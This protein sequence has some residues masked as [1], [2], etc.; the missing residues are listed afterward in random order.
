MYCTKLIVKTIAQ[1]NN[2]AMQF[3]WCNSLMILCT[4]STMATAPP[5][6]RKRTLINIRGMCQSSDSVQT[7]ERR[8][9]AKQISCNK[10]YSL[11]YISLT[12]GMYTTCD[13]VFSNGGCILLID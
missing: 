7:V 9:R 11:L 13:S 1:Q 3:E 2:P 5:A 12:G 6:I 4:I 10:T 8:K